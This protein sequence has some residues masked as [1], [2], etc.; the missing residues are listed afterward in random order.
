[1]HIEPD[2]EIGGF[3]A[4]E[5][6]RLMRKAV[7]RSITVRCVREALDCSVSDASRVL[8]HLQKAGFVESVGSHL[9]PTTKGSALAIA[10]AARPLRRET[11]ARLISNLIERARALNADDQWAYR[12][13]TVV[14]FGSYA[15]G[16]E[17]P[18]D[19]DIG[20]EL[21]PRWTGGEQLV[22]EQLRREIRRQTFRNLTEWT[23]WPRLEV[24]RFLKTRSRGLSIHELEDWILQTTDHAVLFRDE[25]K[26][27]EE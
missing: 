25:S 22:R 11:A 15:R 19:V 5:V 4:I 20:C 16:A 6:R 27:T 2:E 1:M 17:R 21:R 26:T 13:R 8:R 18:N 7:G 14:V 23:A 9:E 3:S 10:T 24:F 12:I